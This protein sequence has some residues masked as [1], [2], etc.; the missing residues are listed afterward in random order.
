M[1]NM[2]V[3]FTF[4][5][6]SIFFFPNL[7]AHQPSVCQAFGNANLV[8]DLIDAIDGEENFVLV[9]IRETVEFVWPRTLDMKMNLTKSNPIQH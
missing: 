8:S 3:T 1:I 5:P 7:K 6:F 2:R 9:I 4:L